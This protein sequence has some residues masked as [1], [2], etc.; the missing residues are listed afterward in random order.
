[1]YAE[2]IHIHC[3]CRRIDRLVNNISQTQDNGALYKDFSKNHKNA[4]DARHSK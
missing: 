3:V 4:D 2:Y 1:M